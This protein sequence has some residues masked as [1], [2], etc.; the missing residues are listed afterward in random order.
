MAPAVKLTQAHQDALQDILKW[1][2][3]VRHFKPDPLPK[4]IRD[5]LQ[6]AMELAPS[7]GN[8]RPWRVIEVE[9]AQTRKKIVAN[10]A[11]AN[12][13]AA[14]IY[15]DATQI[16]YNSLKLEGFQTAPLQL[17]IFT[18]LDTNTGKG[19]GRQ[20]MPEMLQYSTVTAIH[21]LWLAA[22]AHNIGVGWVSILDPDAI[23]KTLNTPSTWKLT[24]YLCIGYAAQS[25]DTP[26]LHRN[27]WQK[28]TA[29]TWSKA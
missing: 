8:A 29:T 10:F 16:K 25:D 23:C 7:V 26:L 2:R 20:S 17:A 21:T 18:E 12:T 1:R 24:G 27:D 13:K 19:L 9:S 3:D 22:R 5:T 4:N 15:T 6:A 11:K 14:A 28:N